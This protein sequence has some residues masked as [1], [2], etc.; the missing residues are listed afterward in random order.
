MSSQLSVWPRCKCKYC[1]V[2]EQS[3]ERM[4]ENFS[5]FVEEYEWKEGEEGSEHIGWQNQ[6]SQRFAGVMGPL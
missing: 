3:V 4:E 6:S 1:L 2:R 5:P